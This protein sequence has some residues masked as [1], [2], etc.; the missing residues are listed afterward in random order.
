MNDKIKKQILN[1]ILEK[2]TQMKK[3]NIMSLLSKYEVIEKEIINESLK[4]NERG[5][6]LLF[7]HKNND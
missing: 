5:K 1:K 3:I 6:I 4:E 2:Q 7:P